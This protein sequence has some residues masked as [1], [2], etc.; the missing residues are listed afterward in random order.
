MNAGERKKSKTGGARY[1][2]LSQGERSEGEVGAA[3][4]SDDD[5]SI[6]EIRFPK[7]TLTHSA[8]KAQPSSKVRS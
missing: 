3:E 8:A 2:T 7:T 5:V 6:G 4:Q 1:S